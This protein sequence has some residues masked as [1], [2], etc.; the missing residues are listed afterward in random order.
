[1]SA[2]P[3]Q[4]PRWAW[5]AA[6][7]AVIQPPSGSGEAGFA[8]AQKPP[9]QWLNWQ[10]NALGAWVD[11]LRGPNVEH[12]IRTAWGTSPATYDA[13]AAVPILAIDTTTVDVTG[14]AYR[15]VVVGEESSGPTTTLR[16][17]RT[18]AEWVRRT[19]I[20]SAPTTPTALGYMAS[21]TRW[22]LADDTPLVYYCAR[23]AGG[24]TG[25]VGSGSG[26]WTDATLPSDDG[27]GGLGSVAAFAFDPDAGTAFALT[28]DGGLYS[29]DGA[30]WTAY[31][32]S[33]TAR[34]GNGADAVWDGANFVFITTDGQVYACGTASG[35]FAYKTTLV[36]GA[37]TWRLAAA[38]A[39]EV[40]AYL[41]NDGDTEDLYFSADSGVSW[42]AITPTTGF[43]RITRIRYHGGQWIATSTVA[44]FL[45]VSANATDWSRVR[46]PAI[47]VS[48]T[49]LALRDV[50]W[51]GGAWMALGNGWVLQCPR[52]IDPAEGTYVA[53]STPAT[54]SDAAYL[55]G[56][57]IATT[58][59]SDGQVYVWVASSSELTPQDPGPWS[60]WDTATVTT[61]DA[62]QTTCGTCTVP[63][64]HGVAF[65][66][67]VVATLRD[68]S[69]S[70]AWT[71]LGSAANNVG[72]VTLHGTPVVT[73]PTDGATT[74]SVTLD[75]SGT[76]LRARVT[77]AAA[78]TID[79]RVTWRAVKSTG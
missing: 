30:T 53:S 73:G 79:W 17:S 42:T 47:P 33:G 41:I 54:L 12:W 57:R 14:L 9:A 3:T 56:R 15:Y 6:G 46:M 23:D 8:T 27:S 28:A 2:R 76:S 38:D 34:S 49:D 24:G 75:V 69:T 50:A 29:S 16:A 62:T 72:T 5:N 35:T 40:L 37:G 13:G 63:T 10:L 78:T 58:A 20:A 32:T 68:R 67:M 55:R 43:S 31:T 11:Y 51:D 44:P 45:W 21:A 77:G 61:T 19:N 65:E 18:G 60:A 36:A 4:V 39:G 48:G 1:M 71:V 70:V 66:A 74:W 25:P 7:G 22:L 59:P 52:G 26:N 64:D